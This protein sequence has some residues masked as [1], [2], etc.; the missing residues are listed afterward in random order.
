MA[1]DRI[2][3]VWGIPVE[4]ARLL[5]AP[6]RGQ[7]MVHPVSGEPQRFV[8]RQAADA[9]CSRWRVATSEWEFS[10]RSDRGDDE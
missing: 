10:V 8:S 6:L 2:W 3:G 9:E 4:L 5:G 1:N 7:W